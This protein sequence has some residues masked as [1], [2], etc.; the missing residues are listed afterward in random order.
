MNVNWCLVLF[1]CLQI[2]KKH[3]KDNCRCFGPSASCVSI[4]CA[5][6]LPQAAVMI[7]NLT[8]NLRFLPWKN[9]RHSVF[10]TLKKLRKQPYGK[11]TL[12]YMKRSPSYCCRDKSQGILGTDN[13]VCLGPDSCKKI[14]CSGQYE[15]TISHNCNCKFEYCCR[16]RC[17][18]CTEQV[19]RC[20]PAACQSS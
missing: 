18:R 16:L 19:F 13:R 12:I 15:A 9:N 6:I 8:E 20:K 3:M 10:S 7:R 5:R 1:S 14:C 11:T 2:V 4:K 17:Q